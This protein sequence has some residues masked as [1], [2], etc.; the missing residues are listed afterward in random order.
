MRKS[1]TRSCR[2]PPRSTSGVRQGRHSY[3][4]GK[5]GADISLEY[6]ALGFTNDYKPQEWTPVGS[7]AW[8]KAMAWDQPRQHAGRGRRALMTGASVPSRSPTCIRRTTYDRNQAIVQEEPVRR[9]DRDVRRRQHVGG[10]DSSSGTGTEH[11]HGR[12]RAM[13]SGPVPA[14]A[15]VRATPCRANWPVSRTSWATCPPPSA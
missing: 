7:V 1:T 6:A 10:D 2:T 14:R 3:L 4:E 13:A 12:A 8:L 9:A 11:R 15:Q 5:D